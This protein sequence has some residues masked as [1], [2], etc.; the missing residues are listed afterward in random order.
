LSW[1]ESPPGTLVF[2]RPGA[3]TCVV[4]LTADPVVLDG[5][6]VLVSDEQRDPTLLPAGSAAWLRWRPPSH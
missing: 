1:R 5:R 4:N 3:L 6:P 2:E